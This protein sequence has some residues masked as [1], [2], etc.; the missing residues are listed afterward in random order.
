MIEHIRPDGGGETGVQ[1]HGKGPSLDVLLL[2]V[3]DSGLG[4][5][6]STVVEERGAALEG[7]GG[8]LIVDIALG[9]PISHDFTSSLK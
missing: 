9:G 7:E 5:E 2:V 6:G 4:V 3:E 1:A 8:G